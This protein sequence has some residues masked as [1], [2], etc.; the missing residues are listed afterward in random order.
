MASAPTHRLP[1]NPLPREASGFS[2]SKCLC[3]GRS[4]R[5]ARD[6][7]L[8]PGAA[9]LEVAGAWRLFEGRV[10]RLDSEDRDGYLYGTTHIEGRGD[11]EG[12]TLDVW[13]K[14]ENL[15]SWLNGSAWVC[16]PDLIS[17]VH[18]GSGRGIYNAE[19]KEGDRV[20]AIGMKG[21]EG[22]PT[23]KGLALARPGHFGFDID[24]VPIEDLLSA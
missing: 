23:E 16:S 13:F 6:R 24:Y 11:H 3:I 15:V 12:Q 18:K 7:G 21:V 4:L 9:T 5:Q 2:V 10:T 8:E 20:V 22:F 19:L 14:N 17:L 1:V